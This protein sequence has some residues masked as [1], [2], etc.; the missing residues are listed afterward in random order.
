MGNQLSVGEFLAVLLLRYEYK[1]R[2]DEVY[3][4]NAQG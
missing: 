4:R 2:K 3:K 1:T